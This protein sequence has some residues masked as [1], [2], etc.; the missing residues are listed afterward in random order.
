MTASA[1]SRVNFRQEDI[2]YRL[3]EVRQWQTLGLDPD[4][5]G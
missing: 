5:H 3:V 2:D 1:R 4:R